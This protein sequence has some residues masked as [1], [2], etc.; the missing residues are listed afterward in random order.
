[1]SAAAKTIIGWGVYLVIVGAAELIIPDLLLR[2]F[3][4]PETGTAYLRIAGILFL[5]LSYYM[6]RAARAE[7]EPF[8]RWTVHARAPIVFVII[9][10]AFLKLVPNVIVLFGLFDFI[11][12]IATALGLR[13]DAKRVL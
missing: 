2:W 12:A 9:V 11:G 4:L 6:F 13:H 8:F 3:D 7:L 5:V 1:M 10:L